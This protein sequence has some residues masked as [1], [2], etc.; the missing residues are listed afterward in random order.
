MSNLATIVNNIL[1]DS[2][3]DDIN[4]VVT[5]G[6]YSNPAWITA[7]AWTKITGTPTTL[8]GYGITNAYTKTEV[9]NIVANY[10]PL[11][12]GTMTGNINWAQTDRGLTW[13]F[14]TD[15]ASIKFY[16]TGDGDT[17]SRLEFATI[18]NNNEYFRWVHI[19]SG[20]SLYESMRLVPNSSGNAELIVTG[21]IIKSG[22]TS[23]QYL[24]ADGSVST[25]TNPVTGTG[26][27]NQITYWTGS[28]TIAALSTATYPSLTE[29]SY[30]KGV[31]SSIQTQLSAKQDTLTLTTTGSSGAATLVGATLNI[32]NYGTALSGYL[33]LTGG[34]LT[35]TGGDL[36]PI[37]NFV[38]SATSNFQWMTW[39]SN[40]SLAAGKTIVHVFGKAQ[41]AKNS[42]AIG[43]QWN[44]NGGNDNFLSLGL[45]DVN[46]ILKL[47]GD[48]SAVFSGTVRATRLGL[49]VAPISDRAL[50]VSGNLPITGTSQYQVVVNGTIVNAVTSGYGIYTATASNVNAT[51][52]FS[53]YIDSITGSGTITNKYGVYQAGT[54]DQ[55][56]FAGNTV[57][58]QYVQTN[59]IS[60]GDTAPYPNAA[61]SIRGAI[62]GNN[63][64]WGVYQN[65]TYSLVANNALAV[66]YHAGGASKVNTGTFTGLSYR[67]FYQEDLAA[68]TGTGTL[69]TAYG[70]YISA[71]T[72]GVANYSAYFAQNVGIGTDVPAYKLDVNGIS[73]FYSSQVDLLLNATST[74]QYSR[75]IFQENGTEK[76]IVQYI[77][78]S[79]S[80]T[81]RR[82]KLEINN[83]DGINLVTGNFGAPILKIES[84][85]VTAV[86]AALG[87]AATLFVASDS[88]TLKTRTAAQVLSDIGAASS[89]SLA[90]YLPLAGGTMTGAISSTL[91][92]STG[93]LRLGSGDDVTQSL[94]YVQIRLGYNGNSADYP[95]FI[96]TTH[97]SNAA[98]GNSIKFY[99]C[100]STAAG[101]YPTNA[102]L[103][104]TIENG[105]IIS[106]AIISKIG[107]SNTIGSGS[108]FNW[109][110]AATS[111]SFRSLA[112]QMNASNGLSLWYHGGTSWADTTLK[113]NNDGSITAPTVTATTFT[114]GFITW[115]AAQI[116]RSSGFVE[117]QYAGGGGVKIF[118]NT[119][120]PITFESG[121]GNATFSS[122]VQGLRFSSGGAVYTNVAYSV[123]GTL[124]GNADSWGVYQNVEFAL[125]A[126]SAYAVG[127]H[128][129]G[130]SKVNTGTFTGLSYRGF[131]Q[132]DLAANT[133]TGT[134]ATA[135][136]I[137]VEGIT[138]ATSNYS[139]FF[140]QNV[141][142][143]TATPN[144]LLHVSGGYANLNGLR[145]SGADTSN[146]IYAGS[147]NTSYTAEPGYN[148]S[149]GRVSDTTKSLNI[150]TTGGNVG[151]RV[152]ASTAGDQYLTTGDAGIAYSNTYFGTGKVRIGGG[153][154]HSTNTVLSVAPGV[155]DF[156]A[157]G[158]VGGRLK[159]NSS[160]YVGISVP[161]PTA[162][163]DVYGVGDQSGFNSL[164]LR[165]G[166]SDDSS[167][168]SNQILFGYNGSANY[169]HAIKTRHQSGS[170]AGNSI[171]FWVWKYGDA[172]STQAGQRVM[173][174]EGNG[175]RIANSS[176]TVNSMSASE[177]LN[178]NG[179]VYATGYFEISDI[180]LKNVLSTTEGDIPAI[181][182]T[183]KDGRDDKLHWG[184]AAQDVMKYLPDAVSGSEYYGLDYNQ[185]HTY[186][187][188]QLESRIKELEQQLK[189]K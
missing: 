28:S 27:A 37:L 166:N 87:S 149:I 13:V 42:A 125:T 79:F 4:V 120:Y 35:N 2:G 167:P 50:Y 5:T 82:K 127:Y 145:I 99:T 76:G 126:N 155:I 107:A 20:G 109:D 56:F 101:I 106:K 75:L 41:S 18:D 144:Q 115:T 139:A 152:S 124:T 133:G 29:L 93:G 178:I 31:T 22:G 177:R 165:A 74:T 66:G 173:L 111:T 128:A 104:L 182:Y 162:Y 30:V 15:G 19:P 1:A 122:T 65:V 113:F 23:S 153:A 114:D 146:S 98:S 54:G 91:K 58:Q 52:I 14:N 17:D 24:M 150:N 78:S 68:N 108:N 72:T 103:G 45:F 43:F 44:S 11:A 176:G 55:N 164:I 16:N 156:D 163:L 102:I 83:D 105:N 90:N 96:T 179:T 136:G 169:A 3:I 185:V 92:N 53:L 172:I 81:A 121:S 60:T 142:I 157:P 143:G 181:T 57:F 118:G 186:K 134:L 170:A 26:T 168:E 123:R 88:G 62:T 110:N 34:T 32:P 7:L 161:S 70:I 184:Y 40:P 119:A 48:D 67:G 80:E 95:H 171:E 189:N 132:Q 86:M 47:F 112:L 159:I 73:R 8:S 33:P 71:L 25:L 9:D 94:G 59:R 61:L 77:N 116:N 129:G 97:N 187:I 158:V 140:A 180:R 160:G 63:D 12:G 147:S 100:D 85:G 151:I 131:Y 137:Y 39:A 141:G 117:L 6:S 49:N 188:A 130:S 84:T 36:T 69:A 183:W 138:R 10:L 154:N 175:V 135:Y 21:K 148:I 46:H 89:S 38:G 174:V 64:S 51:N